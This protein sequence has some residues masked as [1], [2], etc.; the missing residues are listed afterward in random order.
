VSLYRPKV[1]SK[2]AALKRQ[3]AHFCKNKNVVMKLF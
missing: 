3:T 1:G 2:S